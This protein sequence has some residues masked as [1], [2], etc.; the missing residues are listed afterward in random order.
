MA[1]ASL[2]SSVT[3][4]LTSVELLAIDGLGLSTPSYILAAD[5]PH[6]DWRTVTLPYSEQPSLYPEVKDGDGRLRTTLQWYRL[7]LASSVDTDTPLYLYVPRWKS[8]GQIA[9]YGDGHL[10]Y[11]S[12]ANIL[13]NGSN[14]P[15][16]IPLARSSDHGVPQTILLRIEFLRGTGSG[17]STLWVGTEED[18]GWR[19]RLREMLQIQLPMMTS[20]AFLAVGLFS[21]F[22]WIRQRR[23]RLYLLFFGMSLAFYL[24]NMHYY[25]G[26]DRLPVSDEVFGWLTVNALFWL[27]TVSH[28]FLGCLHERHRRWLDRTVIGISLLVSL[29]TLPFTADLWPSATVMAPLIY[30]F[31][32]AMGWLVFGYGLYNSWQVRSREGVILSAWGLLGM[33]V[34]VYDWLLQNNLVSVEGSF[35]GPYTSVLIF[36]IFMYI[37]F[38]R[39]VSAIEDVQT[40]NAGLEQRL[41]VREAELV[42]SH[43]RLREIE[44]RQMLSQERQRLVQD[45]HDGL[46]SSLVSALRVVENGRLGEAEVVEVLKSCIDDLKLAIDS[47][48]PIEAD[49]LLLLATLR[50]RMGSRLDNTGITLL[51]N[52]REVPALDWLDPRNALHILRILQEAFAN[53]LKHAQAREIEV[54]TEAADGWVMVKIKDDGIGFD[55]VPARQRGGKGLSNQ[56][57]RAEAIGG[58]IEIVSGEGGTCTTLFLPEQRPS[59]D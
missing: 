59:P 32:L 18:I 15:L 1:Q 40:L 35:M 47:M 48:E 28:F 4:H 11:R 38:R 25:V 16:W 56:W 30:L 49:L 23:D 51:W 10:L 26:Q 2:S 41:K 53:I 3:E 29:L 34:G 24:R 45:M 57:R 27:I 21:L 19:Y 31:L 9:V 7:H 13:W 50:F 6:G 52:I 8:N 44:H 20:A 55:V 54:S 43:Q 12:H 17:L 58:R 22:V 42:E 36:L 46:G 33:V 37:M 14:H 5:E 39:Y